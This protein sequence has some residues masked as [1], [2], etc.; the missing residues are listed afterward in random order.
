M[1]LKMTLK[2]VWTESFYDMPNVRILDSGILSSI[3]NKSLWVTRY[4]IA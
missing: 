4:Y 2:S 1:T 3:Q